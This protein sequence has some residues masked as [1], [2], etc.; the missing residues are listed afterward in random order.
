MAAVQHQLVVIGA[1]PGG[2]V[3]AIRA[4]QLGLDVACVE[5]EEALGGTCLRVGCIPSKALLESSERYAEAQR[6]LSAHGVRVGDVS[7][8]LPTMMRR[9]AG[10]VTQLTKGVA[11]LFKKHQ[12]KHYRGT[13]RLAGAARVTVEG[14]QPVELEAPHILIATGSRPAGLSGVEVD[15]SRIVTSTEALAFGEVPGRLL[16]IGAGAIGVELGSVWRRLGA[17]VTV[18]EYLDRILPTMDGEMSR[19]ALRSYQ[20]HGMTFELGARVT[21]ARVEGDECVLEIAERGEL[22]GDRVL[23]AVGRAPATDGLGL[24]GLGVACDRRGFIQV[25][26]HFA[27]SVA[28]V[29][30]IGDVIGGAMLAHKASEEGVACV[31]RIATGYG[32]VNYD[33]IPSVVYTEPEV[34]SVG[35]T[36]EQLVEAGVP[37][38]KGS[39]AFKASGRA[40]ALGQTEGAVK[41]LAHGDTDRILGAHLVGPRVSELVS[42]LVVAIECGASSED[43]SRTC[44]AHPTL[45]EV[46]KEA[47]LAVDGR[48]VHG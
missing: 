13:A 38:K 4:A 6:G 44:H 2:Y 42:E 5:F 12:V 36:E 29:Y 16:V 26:E 8:D 34:A 11:W 39:F 19:L 7:L 47:A 35:K 30:A 40:A 15:G 24:E 17:A 22:R 23:L 41:L 10:I 14:S 43:L 28:G 32:H 20:R 33:A 37:F 1:G 21:G 46:V 45:S 9:K 18:V 48:A 31:E 3:A 25:D 27:T